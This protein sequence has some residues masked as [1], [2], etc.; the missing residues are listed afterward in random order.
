MERINNLVLGVVAD[1]DDVCSPSSAGFGSGLSCSSVRILC[2]HPGV[3]HR[4]SAE[5]H[6]SRLSEGTTGGEHTA[7]HMMCV[8]ASCWRYC[9]MMVALSDIVPCQ[10]PHCFLCLFVFSKTTLIIW[11]FSN[12]KPKSFLWIIK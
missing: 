1:C 6:D 8:E 3:V 2:H 9:T 5:G 10:K 7:L 11:H 4:A 12:L